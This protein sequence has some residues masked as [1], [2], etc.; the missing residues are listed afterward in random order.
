MQSWFH[1]DSRCFFSPVCLL[2]LHGFTVSQL[3]Q[4]SV[5]K[6][7][8]RKERESYVK[9]SQSESNHWPSTTMIGL[10]TVRQMQ[11]A[12]HSYKIL[13]QEIHS[14][15]FNLFQEVTTLSED[16]APR[17]NG[18]VYKKW[19]SLR[20]IVQMLI[21]TITLK[22]FALSYIDK[23]G[24]RFTSR[25]LLQLT[26]LPADCW[27]SASKDT[28][29]TLPLRERVASAWEWGIINVIK[30]FWLFGVRACGGPAVPNCTK[31]PNY[32]TKV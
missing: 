30:T 23:V 14:V 10:I 9:A 28:Q 5:K 3:Q 8:K 18:P 27:K 12:R 4:V 17:S 21:P 24:L 32:L 1:S 6:E 25:H 13:Q 16:R 2:H 19:N 29:T 20:V 26:G 15:P 31:V 22:D 7:K 11:L